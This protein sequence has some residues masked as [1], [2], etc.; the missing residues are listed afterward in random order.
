MSLTLNVRL[1]AHD[2]VHVNTCP[3]Q[4]GRLVMTAAAQSN[5]KRVSLELGGKSP[6]IIFPDVD[7]KKQLII[8]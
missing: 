5:L 4:V 8:F 1:S 3:L 6:F 7:R 2:L